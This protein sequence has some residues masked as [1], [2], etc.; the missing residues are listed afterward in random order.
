MLRYQRVIPLSADA[1]V[2]AI[3]RG[4]SQF[5][6]AHLEQCGYLRVVVTLDT[7]ERQAVMSA[8]FT[9]DGTRRWH[10]VETALDLDRSGPEDVDSAFRRLADGIGAA[11][12][13]ELFKPL[14]PETAR[15][16]PEGEF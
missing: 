2:D 4:K 13:A 1:L 3:E 12:I 14:G 15:H 11:R 10:K 6:S 8:S 9:L 5:V 16:N 7:D